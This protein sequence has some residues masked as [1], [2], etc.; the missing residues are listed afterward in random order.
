V[1]NCAAAVNGIDAYPV[2]VEVKV[3]YGGTL[4][5]MIAMIHPQGTVG[6]P[7]E[8]SAKHGPETVICRSQPAWRI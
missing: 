7:V 6:V 5:V 8:L 1:N 4:V 3:G 2:E